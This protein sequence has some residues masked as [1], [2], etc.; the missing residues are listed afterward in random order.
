MDDSEQKVFV[1]VA[2]WSSGRVWGKKLFLYMCCMMRDVVGNNEC[3]KCSDEGYTSK[4]WK[5]VR[6]PRGPWVKKYVFK[7]VR[8]KM[9]NVVVSV[10]LKFDWGTVS[11]W[12]HLV[13][14]S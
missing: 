6:G 9:W 3:N 2:R 14:C 5:S 1:N 11:F 7:K 8:R 13:V 4:K 12:K 10:T